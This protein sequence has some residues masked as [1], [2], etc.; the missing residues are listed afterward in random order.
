MT[1][2]KLDMTEILQPQTAPPNKDGLNEKVLTFPK[3]DQPKGN[4]EKSPDPTSKSNNQESS[5]EHPAKGSADARPG[6]IKYRYIYVD[7]EDWKEVE[8][9]HSPGCLPGS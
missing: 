6:S 1:S 5:S 2:P 3:T 7:Q 9:R 8:S 4:P